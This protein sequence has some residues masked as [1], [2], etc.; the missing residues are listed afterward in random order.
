MNY[1]IGID[2]GGTKT[3]FVLADEK[4]VEL[5]RVMKK[6]CNPNDVG[7]EGS[8]AV[9]DDGIKELAVDS[10]KTYIF[11]G[12]SGAG[13][14]DNAKALRDKL[15]EKYENV[16][17][18]SDLINALESSLLGKDGVAVICGTGI[19]CCLSKAGAYKTIGGYGYL[20][21]DGG[22]GYTYGRDGVK[23]ALK[24]EDG[25]GEKTVLL[26]LFREKLGKGVRNSLAQLLL[27]GKSF[28][29]SLCPLVFEG[30]AAGDAVCKKIVEE[31]LDHTVALIKSAIG[32]YGDKVRHIGFIGGVTREKVFRERMEA[33]LGTA[34]ELYYADE[35]PVFGAV[36]RA[37]KMSKGE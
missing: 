23:A 33:E 31:N 2:G 21:E 26:Q 12:V 17:V 19:S 3:E 24:Y 11:A 36:R 14:G 32:L 1:Y 4:G 6:G 7:I 20:F 34:H 13:V 29:A 8:F 28:V 10:G 25:Y 18:A 22:S 35:K 27:G 16:E 9:L 37:I 15:S 30:M 5:R